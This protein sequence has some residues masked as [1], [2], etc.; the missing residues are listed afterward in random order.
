MGSPIS[1]DTRFESS[2]VRTLENPTSEYWGAKF[3]SVIFE[4]DA[5]MSAS[6]LES[7]QVLDDRKALDRMLNIGVSVNKEMGEKVEPGLVLR[8]A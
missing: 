6:A 7:S 8:E 2:P 3:V 4:Q 1:S 5:P